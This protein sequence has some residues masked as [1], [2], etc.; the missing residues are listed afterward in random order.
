MRLR[1]FSLPLLFGI[2]VSL[3]SGLAQ[4]LRQ[5]VEKKDSSSVVA[6]D[7]RV[8]LISYD[9]PEDKIR[10]YRALFEELGEQVPNAVHYKPR[11][12]VG[13][14]AD[15]VDW[16]TRGLVDIAVLSP[17]A[18]AETTAWK[19]NGP[20]TKLEPDCIYLATEGKAPA[21]VDG[22]V[23]D[24]AKGSSEPGKG[25]FEYNSVC[26][27]SADSEIKNFDQ[28]KEAAEKGEVQ[29]I[30]GDPLSASGTI[31][32][33][34]F[35]RTHGIDFRK[36][37]E[38][39]FGHSDSVS[40]ILEK[41][42]A[43]ALS[44]GPDRRKRVAFV[45]DLA[46]QD[47]QQNTPIDKRSNLLLVQETMAI[48]GMKD[49]LLPMEV[50]VARKDFDKGSE[51]G[52]NPA[53]TPK[54]NS[55]RFRAALLD[56]VARKRQSAEQERIAKGKGNE[57]PA[58]REEVVPEI[59]DFTHH[60]EAP[61]EARITPLHIWAQ[62][63]KGLLAQPENAPLD[64]EYSG[65][66][67][68]KT[69]GM[70]FPV[71]FQDIVSLIR[72][73]NRIYKDF[74]KKA[75]L[76]LVLSGGG[77][78]C[79]YQAGAIEKIED[80]LRPPGLPVQPTGSDVDIDL[81]VGTSG[82]ALNAVPIAVGVS[83]QQMKD[84]PLALT[85]KE[86]NALNII[87]PPWKVAICLGLCY[88]F[89][90]F[91][92]VR[93][94]V[95]VARN[96]TARYKEQEKWIQ[97][98]G[99]LL[100]IVPALVF[101]MFYFPV[102]LHPL[103]LVDLHILFYLLLVISCGVFVAAPLCVAWGFLVLANAHTLDI[104]RNSHSK[105]IHRRL[106]SALL[107]WSDPRRPVPFLDLALVGMLLAGIALFFALS[108]S[109][110]LF[111]GEPLENVVIE[112]Y[113]QLF[114]DPASG[115]LRRDGGK[116]IGKAIFADKRRTRDLVITGSSLT[117]DS[118]GSKYFYLPGINRAGSESL[119]SYG[120]NGIEIGIDCDI[121]RLV[122]IALGSGTIFPFFPS[123]RV[124]ESTDKNRHGKPYPLKS[125]DLIDGG[126][127]HNSPIEAATRWKATHIVLIDA[128]P[129]T[130]ERGTPKSAFVSNILKAIGY[131]FDQAQAADVNAQEEAAVFT[132]RPSIIPKPQIGILDFG[133]GFV[134]DA[135]ER[136]RADAR[137]WSFV[138]Q[139]AKPLFWDTESTV[140]P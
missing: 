85:W 105:K 139:P 136:G 106:L 56:H 35:L 21:A 135:L 46:V 78:K 134:E 58:S 28:L 31:F 8:G 18:F 14:Y 34:H 96:R 1:P 43:S 126:F 110:G 39:S 32:P 137:G 81:V 10:D 92:I 26:I 109:G 57:K 80:T 17:N 118:R 74:P 62:E 4:Q 61:L 117:K 122:D 49:E 38:Y 68:A 107:R 84:P 73:Y 103:L 53:P 79:A 88:A 54:K 5:T 120:T 9:K 131:L 22:W 128:S 99:W 100:I 115:D 15:V 24:K 138:R 125:M 12:A 42:S 11:F 123:H 114:S 75:R 2:S 132:L 86:L 23:N 93:G 116:E 19:T 51:Q 27:A 95:R 41:N 76:A 63:I 83:R 108:H 25:R 98:L 67:A 3:Q 33:M 129:E 71:R 7:L 97:L 55:E 13:T 29:F 87:R 37:M 52:P 121:Q 102:L 30:F 91:V 140:K 119:P 101:I 45:Q 89:L 72:H 50:W 104:P 70:R 94:F 40:L 20:G 59:R 112:Q 48:K 90:Y 127:A 64:G 124:E 60:D 69:P 65:D 111:R 6:V 77:A 66:P 113:A 36:H 47:T 130:I 133:P 44:A 16:I 82:G